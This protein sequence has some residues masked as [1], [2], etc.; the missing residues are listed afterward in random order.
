MV[1]PTAAASSFGA[2]TSAFA[3]FLPFLPTTRRQ[4]AEENAITGYPWV[5]AFYNGKKIEDMAG[6]GG[7]D[8]IV[9]FGIRKA[10]EVGC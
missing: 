4:V 5:A 10:N 6:L 7:A 8:S 1:T 9:N 2:P 3:C